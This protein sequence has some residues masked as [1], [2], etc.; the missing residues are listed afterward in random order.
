MPNAILNPPDTGVDVS[1]LLNDLARTFAPIARLR[2]ISPSVASATE[3]VVV[4]T[5]LEGILPTFIA[6][7]LKVLYL[8]RPGSR[9][10]VAA[11]LVDTDG[12]MHLR[13]QLTTVRFYMNP[14]LFLADNPK[15]LRLDNT[16]ADSSIIYADLLLDDEPEPAPIVAVQPVTKLP[17]ILNSEKL[18][19]ATK[20]RIEQFMQDG[21]TIDR[22]RA[23]SN[24]QEARFLE[25]VG[26]FITTNL[27]NAAFD[28]GQLER[29]VGL[30]RSQL[31]RKLKKL[32]GFSTANYIR[33]VRLCQARTLLETTALPISEVAGRVGFA[34]LSYF[35]HAFSEAFSQTPSDWRKKTRMQQ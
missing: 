3:P 12:Q 1:A 11:R 28:S 24:V 30:S 6:F 7:W 9:F 5:S 10:E 26:Q 4:S 2:G 14:N 15:I 21:L 17:E 25:T 27:G 31:F 16:P 19:T 34:E 32:T 18:A 29:D 8:I 35:S 13:L 23:S 20:Q 33:H 22:V